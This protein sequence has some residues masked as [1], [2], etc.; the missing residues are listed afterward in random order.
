MPAFVAPIY[1]GWLG[2]SKV[3]D[4]APP[5]FTLAAADDQISSACVEL[6]KAWRTAGKPDRNHIYQKD[7]HGFGM[8]KRGMDNRYLD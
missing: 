7:G 1:G 4:A 6:Y 8:Q 3:P 5:L 2:E